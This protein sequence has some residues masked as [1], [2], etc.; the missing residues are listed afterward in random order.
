[1]KMKKSAGFQPVDLTKVV[2]MVY[3]REIDKA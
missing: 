1:M 3:E 2:V